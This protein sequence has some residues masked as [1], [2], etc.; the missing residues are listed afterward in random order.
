MSADE[1]AER[2]AAVRARIAAACSRTDRDPATITLI[3][4]GKG[5]PVERLLAAWRA[6]LTDFGE[7]RVQEALAKAPGLPA[8][9]HWH[10]LGP[11]QSNKVNKAVGLFAS[12]HSFD[13]VELA[14]LL[15]HRCALADRRLPCF[16]EVN[17]AGEASKHGFAP[18]AVAE[19]VVS[20][21][22]RSHLEPV[23]LM[24][25][26]PPTADPEA[27]RP[28]FRTLARLAAELVERHGRARFPG[29]LSIGM[30]DD[31]EVAVE[32]GATHV[33]IGTALFGERR[34]GAA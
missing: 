13:R 11:L 3:G 29:C 10:L 17:L 22:T 1:V 20:L 15:E 18:A 34:G 25:I 7:N 16:V 32:E 14:A 23:G 31:F 5:Q 19:A 6:G 2:V 21:L 4:A 12:V 26:P 27:S 33:R 28:A 8:G 24:A 9:A 30:S